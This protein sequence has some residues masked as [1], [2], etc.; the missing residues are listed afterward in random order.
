MTTYLP[1]TA[2]MRDTA[3]ARAR[4]VEPLILSAGLAA[5]MTAGL[6]AVFVGP[7][8]VAGV[9]AV[10]I[11]AMVAWR[12]VLALLSYL[13]TLPFLAGV[14][15]GQWLPLL[16]PNEALLVL[17]LFG[18][19][20]GGLLRYMRGARL[21]LRV[22]RW[23]VAVAGFFVLAIGWPVSSMLVRGLVP[24]GQDLAALLPAAKL[25]ALVVLGRLTVRTSKDLLWCLWL[26][27]GGAVV[28]AAMSVLQVLGIEPVV[29]LIDTYY[30]VL[31]RDPHRATTTL[32][33]AIATGDFVLGGTVLLLMAGLRG[34]IGRARLVCLP[35]LAVG[36][37]AAGQFS[38]WIG[39]MIVGAVVLH[40]Y[41]PLRKKAV[42]IIPVIAL[43]MVVAAPAL[44]DRLNDFSNSSGAPT[45]WLV[46][47]VNVR[48]LY[49]PPLF[50]QKGFVL[51]VSPNSV[52]VPPDTWRDVVYLESGYLQLLWMG[53]IPLLAGFI[54][55]TTAVLSGGRR[56][57]TRTDITGAC[58]E[59]LVVLWWV[60]LIM[61][62][63]DPHLS[64][65][66]PGDL[67]FVLLGITLTGLTE[68]E[69]H[70]HTHRE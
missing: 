5:A 54:W 4:A 32:S 11:F 65:R 66:G 41:P 13:L 38:T 10:A 42:R 58:A 68:R 51:G 8:A 31:P 44:F 52:L 1:D 28:I 63:T 60:V 35:V 37:V 55:L 57:S 22:T 15:R 23:D 49:L 48:D 50:E 27:V 21:Q 30:P 33:N 69:I 40:R 7:L 56:V 17:V 29:G 24:S 3:D 34:L 43:A 6:A 64:M 39:A 61:S 16:R 45:S 62:V 70:D 53:G 19:L 46:R 36:L 26:I 67:L 20:A 14:D 47:W 18:A 9:V 59:T 25:A 2:D 12:P